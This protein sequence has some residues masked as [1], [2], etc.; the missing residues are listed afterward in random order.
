MHAPPRSNELKS[1]TKNEISLHAE[2]YE[3]GYLLDMWD[4]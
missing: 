4:V 3:G 1:V 2:Y